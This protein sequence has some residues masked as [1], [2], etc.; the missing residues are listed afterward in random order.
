MTKLNFKVPFLTMDGQ[1]FLEQ[2]NQT[3]TRPIL[4]S[5]LLGNTLGGFAAKPPIDTTYFSWII[6]LGKSGVLEV[7]DNSKETLIKFIKEDGGF[8]VIQKGRLLEVFNVSVIEPV[9][10]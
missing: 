10:E 9:I 6:E 2:V 7:D 3:E 8:T 1:P 5:K 4:L